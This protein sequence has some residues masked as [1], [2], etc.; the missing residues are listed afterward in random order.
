MEI[1]CPVLGRNARHVL[2]KGDLRSTPEARQRKVVVAVER[3]CNTSPARTDRFDGA[4]LRLGTRTL[5]ALQ[6]GRESN[7]LLLYLDCL[8]SVFSL[9]SLSF[10]AV[11]IEHSLDTRSEPTVQPCKKIGSSGCVKT[12]L[13]IPL[14]SGIVSSRFRKKSI[15]P[16]KFNHDIKIKIVKRVYENHWVDRDPCVVKLKVLSTVRIGQLQH[17]LQALCSGASALGLRARR[18]QTAGHFTKLTPSWSTTTCVR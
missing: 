13:Y 7:L 16:Q 6:R 17:T 4:A 3:R 1:G 15:C 9:L 12:E 14:R 18:P 5:P 8:S 10:P 11:S 2:L